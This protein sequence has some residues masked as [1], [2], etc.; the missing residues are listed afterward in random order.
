MKTIKNMKS[1]LALTLFTMLSITA[2]TQATG[3]MPG[4][5][6][7]GGSITQEAVK[8]AVPAAQEAA[9]VACGTVWPAIANNMKVIGINL[10]EMT[11]LVGSFLPGAL[12]QVTDETG[13]I[14]GAIK[15]CPI[16]SAAIVTYAAYKTYT[17]Y[18]ADYYNQQNN[19]QYRR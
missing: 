15:K 4:F 1:K 19:G 13:L 5:E 16:V 18:Y 9:K 2:V 3:N 10:W 17:W 6:N 7:C 8:L 11:K 12:K 14:T